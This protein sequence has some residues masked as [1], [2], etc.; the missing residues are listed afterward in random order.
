M[1]LDCVLTP[2]LHLSAAFQHHRK[3]VQSNSTSTMDCDA[4]KRVA[5]NIVGFS[6][7]MVG[8]LLVSTCIVY[9]GCKQLLKSVESI[10]APALTTVLPRLQPQLPPLVI[11]V[12]LR[13]RVTHP[14]RPALIKGTTNSD[15]GS[16][17]SVASCSG[18][19][20]QSSVDPVSPITDISPLPHNPDSSPA[21][22]DETV[23]ILPH[24]SPTKGF[25]SPST[26]LDRMRRL[27]PN[28]RRL[29]SLD[30][31][32]S[33][34]PPTNRG[35]PHASVLQ[36]SPR[37]SIDEDVR[38]V[39]N[40][41]TSSF[42]DHLITSDARPQRSTERRGRSFLGISRSTKAQKVLAPSLRSPTSSTDTGDLMPVRR[43]N[44]LTTPCKCF[45][46][47][48]WFSTLI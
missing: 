10:V 43:T 19:S 34:L 12:P 5:V 38:D 9:L 40:A 17:E 46:T 44:S 25:S 11:K 39:A 24:S 3:V 28:S 21:Q 4:T 48:L 6:M 1:P 32:A 42:D 8:M 36:F 2:R 18:A 22:G 35:S 27:R 26:C 41:S 15:D 23:D 13:K 30:S 37:S 20:S 33:E 14:R 47:C 45:R 16:V 29:S 31:T 7:A